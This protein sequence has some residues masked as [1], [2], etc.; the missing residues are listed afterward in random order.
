V[1]SN[2]SVGANSFALLI[3]HGFKENTIEYSQQLVPSGNGHRLYNGKRGSNC[4]NEFAPTIE[5]TS[6]LHKQ[7]TLI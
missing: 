3:H 6:F 7:V 4:A 2:F 1:K 5:H